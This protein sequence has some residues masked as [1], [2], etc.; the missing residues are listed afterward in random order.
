MHLLKTHRTH[1][2]MQEVARQL[3]E[4]NDLSISKTVSEISRLFQTAVRSLM[5]YYPARACLPSSRRCCT[6][7]VQVGPKLRGND[8]RKMRESQFLR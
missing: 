6:T 8:T 7:D 3:C 1:S 5:V 4:D 2:Y